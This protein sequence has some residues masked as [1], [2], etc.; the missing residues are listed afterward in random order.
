MPQKGRKS[1]N[2]P[3]KPGDKI[4]LIMIEFRPEQ[5]VWECGNF[6]PGKSS[7]AFPLISKG[8]FSANVR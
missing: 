1:R 3:E 2:S 7:S 4:G 5:D 6:K 8:L